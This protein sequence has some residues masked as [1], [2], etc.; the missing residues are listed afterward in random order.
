MRSTVLSLT[1]HDSASCDID[2][3]SSRSG[4]HSTHSATMR[5]AE[6]MAGRLLRMRAPAPVSLRRCDMGYLLLLGKMVS[7]RTFRCWCGVATI[8]GRDRPSVGDGDEHGLS[9]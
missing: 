3:S 4:W 6:V 9:R 1:S 8:G 7:P 5:S 2:S